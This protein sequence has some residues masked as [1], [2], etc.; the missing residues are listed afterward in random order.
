MLSLLAATPGLLV[1]QTPPS[2][3][4]PAALA[5]R[6]P[7]FSMSEAE[8][9]SA[10][11]PDTI[12]TLQTK[13]DGWDDVRKAIIDGKKE[14]AP[15]LDKMKEKYGPG[16]RTA[17][18][19]AKVLATEVAG[20]ELSAPK[21]EAPKLDGIKAPKLSVPKLDGVVVPTSLK[22]AGKNALFGALDAAAARK[23][24]AKAAEAK[25]EEAARAAKQGNS[26]FRRR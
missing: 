22:E 18:R 24:A 6:A 14:R 26:Y 23:Q 8:E 12:F 5:R 2:A 1:P 21:L 9:A 25:A 7:A 3:L 20:V 11:A 13:G 4:R 19:W 15:T 10:A 16:L 17:G